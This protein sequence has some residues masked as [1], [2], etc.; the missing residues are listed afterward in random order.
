MVAFTANSTEVEE[1][2]IVSIL[3]LGTCMALGY[4]MRFYVL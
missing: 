4:F 3:F 2:N 1:K